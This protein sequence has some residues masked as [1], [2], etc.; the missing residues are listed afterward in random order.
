[1]DLNKL[2]KLKADIEQ[3]GQSFE[4]GLFQLWKIINDQTKTINDLRN[5][6]ELLK[7]RERRA[8]VSSDSSGFSG[9]SKSSGIASLPGSDARTVNSETSDSSAQAIPDLEY[10]QVDND[11]LKKL[12]GFIRN[13]SHKNA[14]K[15]PLLRKECLIGRLH[16]DTT[17]DAQLISKIINPLTSEFDKADFKILS[18][19]YGGLKQM[20]RFKNLFNGVDSTSIRDKVQLNRI[21]AA[22]KQLDD[23]IATSEA[24]LT[25]FKKYLFNAISHLINCAK[26]RDEIYIENDNDKLPACRPS[27]DSGVR[28]TLRLKRKNTGVNRTRR[29]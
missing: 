22:F 25:M 21:E 4:E 23:Y 3:K 28:R 26:I 18:Q 20:Q 7:R 27:I 1:M 9:V 17:K 8:S 16:L 15:Y 13:C 14:Y 12:G 2:R 6:N 11:E 29:R 19:A 5:E 24:D 10:A